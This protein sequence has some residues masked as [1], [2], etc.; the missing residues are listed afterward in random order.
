VASTTPFQK[1]L[2]QKK[3]E[4]IIPGDGQVWGGINHYDLL[5]RWTIKDEE[6]D[7]LVNW[8]P[9]GQSLRQV[10]GLS[11]VLATLVSPI[12]WMTAQ[13]L[14]AAEFIFA[15]CQNGHVYQV[16]VSGGAIT[17]VSGATTLSSSTDIAN[18]QGTT[19]LLSD[20]ATST[21]YAWNGTTFGV[22]I[23]SPNWHAA[24]IT[25][26]GG[27][28]WGAFANT[29]Q[30]TDTNTY[31]SLSGS[32][33]AF[34]ITEFECSKGILGLIPFNGQLYIWGPNYNQVLGNLSVVGSPPVLQFAKYTLQAQIGINNKWSVVAVGQSLFFTNAYGAW[35][36]QGAVPNKISTPVDGIIT[37]AGAGSTF[38]GGLV[39]IYGEPC[40]MWNLIYSGNPNVSTAN[41]QLGMTTNQQWFRTVFGPITFIASDNYLDLPTMWATDGTKIWQMF[42]STSTNVTSYFQTKIFNMGSTILYKV[43]QK[44]GFTVLIVSPVALTMQAVDIQ[45]NVIFSQNPN[46]ST[47]ISWINNFNQLITW[48]NNSSAVVTWTPQA[49]YLWQAWQFDVATAQRG[50]GLQF[51]LVGAGAAFCSIPIEYELSTAAWG[52]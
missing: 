3:I 18:W 17:D 1:P 36:L 38:A 43:L 48:I 34:V 33:G 20:P 8:L 19:I 37:Q 35:Q 2:D 52:P 29:I 22:A 13:T 27:R 7:D 39:Q 42:A 25:V 11:A 15:L 14:N 46:F 30:F 28:L 10:P 6:F 31:N 12:I 21:L 47:I 44:F 45:G 49:P 50:F 51:A 26:F 4:A 5:S 40:L 41:T 9:M 24:Y 16:A 23:A 32:A